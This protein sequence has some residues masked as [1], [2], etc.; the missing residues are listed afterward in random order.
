MSKRHRRAYRFVVHFPKSSAQIYFIPSPRD[1]NHKGSAKILFTVSDSQPSIKT[2]RS[3]RFVA[4]SFYFIKFW[5]RSSIT[6]KTHH[7]KLTS[8][9]ETGPIDYA[10]FRHF[11]NFLNQPTNFN[12][13]HRLSNPP[14]IQLLII[15]SHPRLIDS[16][17]RREHR[18][19][20]RPVSVLQQPRAVIL[21]ISHT[22]PHTHTQNSSHVFSV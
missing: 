21:H 20:I 11:Y 3:A 16:S 18:Q 13:Y 17:E 22:Q 15:E 8:S 5:H 6:F 1:N 12:I 19:H 14:K 7:Q 9:R 2:Q 10:S 4:S